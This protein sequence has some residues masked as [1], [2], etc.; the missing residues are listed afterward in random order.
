MRQTAKQPSQ[1][2]SLCFSLRRN[3]IRC[4]EQERQRLCFSFVKRS[5]RGRCRV[6][7]FFSSVL[8]KANNLAHVAYDCGFYHA[9]CHC[10]L[11]VARNLL[12]SEFVGFFQRIQT[13]AQKL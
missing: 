3:N 8:E 13:A 6:G 7:V 5:E 2:K 4:V 10:V 12:V 11:R 1:I 9:F